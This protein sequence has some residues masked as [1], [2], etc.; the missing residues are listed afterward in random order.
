MDLVSWCIENKSLNTYHNFFY[1]F[2]EGKLDDDD[3]AASESKTSYSIND[4][5]AAHQQTESE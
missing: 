3:K 5:L 2:S 1:W 4:I